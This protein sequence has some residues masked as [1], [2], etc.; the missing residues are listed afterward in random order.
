MTACIS[1]RIPKPLTPEFFVPD[2]R[3]SSG[4]GGRCRSCIEASTNSKRHP[5]PCAQCG[6]H[7]LLY[8]NGICNKCNTAMGLR[9]CA[10]C[11]ELLPLLV[12]FYTGKGVCKTCLYP[13]KVM[14][15][16]GCG[17]DYTGGRRKYCS[18]DCAVTGRAQ[19]K[20][21]TNAE[22]DPFRKRGYYL[23]RAYGMTHERFDSL[24]SSQGG[25]CA[26]CREAAPRGES[27]QWH[28]DHDHVTGRVR[29]L[30]CRNCNVGLRCFRDSV[31]GLENAVQYL[32]KARLAS[33]GP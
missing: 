18:D 20:Q 2:K 1:C 8:L 26:I 6:R 25:V 24:L 27:R 10:R 7:R 13:P 4:F 32:S 5:V 12:S 28:V 31:S 29:G 9:Q 21:V 17:R 14:V 22:I 33:G 11:E 30:L 3:T 19:K 15:C 23:K 16:S